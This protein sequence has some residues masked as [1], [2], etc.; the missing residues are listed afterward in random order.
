M[1]NASLTAAK[2]HF[3]A[4]G[5][6]DWSKGYYQ[7]ANRLAHLHFLTSLGIE[8]YLVFT[9]FKDDNSVK[10][11]VNEQAWNLKLKPMYQHLGLGSSWPTHHVYNVFLPAK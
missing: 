10:G 2:K 1:I 5:N 9:Y 6:L 7:Y 3:Q 4:V 11:P 8:A